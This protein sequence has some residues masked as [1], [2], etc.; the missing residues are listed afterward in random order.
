[1]A[2]SGRD[3][4]SDLFGELGESKS[5]LAQAST[6]KAPKPLIW[7]NLREGAINR[8]LT[9]EG[10]S[11]GL[12]Y[13]YVVQLYRARDFLIPR[14]NDGYVRDFHEAAFEISQP[15]RMR[16]EQGARGDPDAD[17]DEKRDAQYATRPSD[18]AGVELV[19]ECNP[20]DAV[21]I[22]EYGSAVIQDLVR[23]AVAQNTKPLKESNIRSFFRMKDFPEK[24]S[25]SVTARHLPG[26]ASG[27]EGLKN[28]GRFAAL[29]RSN[30]WLSYHT[31]LVS[32]PKLVQKFIEEAAPA[33]GGQE[34][35]ARWMGQETYESVMRS[36]SS[37]W[38]REDADNISTRVRIA[39][40]VWL[41][42]NNVYPENWY[43]GD[44]ALASGNSTL[45]RSLELLFRRY[46][47]LASNEREIETFQ[48][49]DIQARLFRM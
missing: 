15:A 28:Q 13:L 35:L 10:E 23:L 2:G 39:T 21:I 45:K 30:K 22:L 4:I 29:V 25:G 33:F 3:L 32:T 6:R 43:Q 18:L 8:V 27:L 16:R 44:A 37:P 11:C 5:V 34:E 38:E 42:V 17:D 14:L 26:L 12:E 36:V 48:P 41:K 20:S 31:T 7:M 9:D 46:L 47:T 24:M 40:A 1:M 19:G 49:A